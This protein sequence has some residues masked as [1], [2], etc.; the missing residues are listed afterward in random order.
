VIACGGNNKPCVGALCNKPC[1][2]ALC[3]TPCVGALWG[4]IVQ[5]AVCGCIVQQAVCGCIVQHAVCNKQSMHTHRWRFLEHELGQSRATL[6]FRGAIP[7]D[8]LRLAALELTKL[9]LSQMRRHTHQRKDSERRVRC[10]MCY[11]R[12]P[13][14]GESRPPS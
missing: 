14:R 3:N 6:H 9:H 10:C 5:H 4:C 11:T 12:V 13:L 8:N 7:H 2:G 1:V